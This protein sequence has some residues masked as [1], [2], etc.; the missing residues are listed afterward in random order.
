L[1]SA[2]CQSFI[3]SPNP[4]ANP[5]PNVD[6]IVNDPIVTVGSQ[7]GCN[8]AQN[9]TTIDVNHAN[10]RNLVA[11]AND[12]RYFNTRENRN[13]S[14][15][16]AY[17]SFDGGATWTNVTLPHLTFQTGATGA[18]SDMDG[19]GDPAIAFGSHNTVYYANIA[20]S[21]LNDGSAITVSKS[22]DG[23]SPGASRRSSSSTGRMRLAI[24]CPRRTSTTRSGSP[25]TRRRGRCT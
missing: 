24:P 17:T 25:S 6:A 3:G 21:R 5:A 11:G 22:T 8:T 7:T 12:Y 13:D 14:S 10:P 20:F 23:G 9:E 18:L 4:Y 19:A 15:G 1:R 16:V 2:L